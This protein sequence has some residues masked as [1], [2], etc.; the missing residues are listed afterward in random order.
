MTMRKCL[1]FI[2]FSI[3]A[4]RG[5][6]YT[7][8]EGQI[9]VSLGPSVYQTDYDNSNLFHDERWS[10]GFGLLLT[11]DLSEN[12]ALELS[13]FNMYKTY[14]REIQNRVL[15]EK[16]ALLHIAMGYRRYWT[17]KF[18]SSISFYSAY[19]M[20]RRKTLFT[21]LLPTDTLTTS[22]SDITEYGMDLALQYQVW[23]QGEQG[24]VLDSRYAYSITNK[25]REY[26]N[27]YGFYLAY[28]RSVR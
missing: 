2:L 14:F 18:S 11:G 3:L 17:E 1:L 4:L 19:S 20:G 6:A 16:T 22:A 24:V 23:E 26:G 5:Q 9:Q 8:K 15:A 13:M 10:G 12:S 28:R 27:H 7:P 21:D 25:S